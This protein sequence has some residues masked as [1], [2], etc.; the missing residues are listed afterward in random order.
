[1]HK[2]SLTTVDMPLPWFGPVR[3]TALTARNEVGEGIVTE[4][5]VVL[6]FEPPR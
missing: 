6:R 1:M 2:R 3:S 5:T 4:Y